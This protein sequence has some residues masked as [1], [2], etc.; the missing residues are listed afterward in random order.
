MTDHCDGVEDW[1][2]HHRGQGHDPDAAPTTGNSAQWDC[3][4][5]G[6]NRIL[7]VEQIA[8]KFAHSKD[9]PQSLNPDFPV[10]NTPPSKPPCG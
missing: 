10:P 1:A 3:D 9:R 7:T 5:G 4:C 8:K 6:I 2:A